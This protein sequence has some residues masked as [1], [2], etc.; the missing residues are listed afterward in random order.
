MSIT[1]MPLGSGGAPQK[2]PIVEAKPPSLH[3]ALLLLIDLVT[4]GCSVFTGLLSK[5]D[6]RA[7]SMMKVG[8][9]C[10]TRGGWGYSPA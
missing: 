4:V 8:R 1:P 9:R 6:L 7:R 3:W 2:E 5:P 10:G